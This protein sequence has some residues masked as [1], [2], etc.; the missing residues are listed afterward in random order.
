MLQSRKIAPTM[1]AA[2]RN[3][4]LLQ[5]AQHEIDRLSAE[6]VKPGFFGKVTVEL[7]F[8]DGRAIGFETN[9]KQSVRM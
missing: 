6:A 2:D 1:N 7:I 5:G 3:R 9:L 8:Q 4:E